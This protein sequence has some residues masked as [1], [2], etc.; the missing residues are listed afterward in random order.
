MKVLVS[1]KLS[2]EGIDQLKEAGIQ[3]DV[4]L[5]L[6]EDELAG[7]IGEYDGILVRSGTQVTKRIIEAGRNLKVIGR[8]GVGVDNID[9]LAASQRGIVVINAP[10]GN[11]LA[12][13]EHAVAMMFTLARNIPQAHACLTVGKKWDRK[14]FMGVQLEGKTLGVIGLGRIGKTVAQRALAMN[15]NVIGYDPYLSA[16]VAKRLGVELLEFEQVLERADFLT[17]H[18]PKTKSTENMV[19]PREFGLMKKGVR[20]INCA[21]GGIIDEDALYAAIQSGKVAGAALDVFC[22]EPPQLDHPLFSCSQVVVTPHL[23]AST[24]EA[25]VNVAVD[26]AEQAVCVLKG[27]PF[28]NAVNLPAFRPELMEKLEP[29]MELASRLGQVYTDLVGGNHQ[30]IEV[31][32]RGQIASYDVTPLTTAVLKGMLE[33]ILHGEVNYVNASLLAKERGIRVAEIREEEKDGTN[34]VIILRNTTE[35]DKQGRMVAGNLTM[36]GVPQLTRIDGYPVNVL[37]AEHLLV[38]YHIDKPGIIGQVGTILGRAK[39]NIA[40]MQ[41]GRKAISGNAVMVLSVDTPVPEDVLQEMS[42]LEN[43]TEVYMAQ[44]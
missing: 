35:G 37:P 5:G 21:R 6:N 14:S 12:A 10:E 40:A 44:W 34:A 26:V 3:V 29:Y 30:S 18:I 2:Q 23:G 38:A 20:I 27:K 19:G 17:F 33:P 41:V 11:T 7:I 22:T 25:Q 36:N 15:M 13:A 39:I 28:Q 42:K 24:S 43:I 4:K 9:L 8:A 16:E 32:Y 1:D 31:V